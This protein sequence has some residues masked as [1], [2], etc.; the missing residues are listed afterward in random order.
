MG[1]EKRNCFFFPFPL[2]P[3]GLPGSKR[4]NPLLPRPAR[5]LFF[6]FSKKLKKKVTLYCF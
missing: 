6:S 1:W 5:M 4:F 2:E 3:R